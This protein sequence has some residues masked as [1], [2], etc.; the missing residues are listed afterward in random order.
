MVP[1]MTGKL[2]LIRHVDSTK[3]AHEIFDDPKA[4]QDLTSKGEVELIN[5]ISFLR[6]LVEA[7]GASG[8]RL[9]AANSERAEKTAQAIGAELSFKA[10]KVTNLGS[11]GSGPLSGLSEAEAA[12]KFPEYMRTLQL[13]RSGVLSSDKIVRPDGCETLSDY[14]HRISNCVVEI[15]QSD[16]SMAI[17]VG[18]RSPISAICVSLARRYLGYPNDF[19]GYIEIPTGSVTLFDF[20][21]KDFEYIGVRP[22]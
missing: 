3:N 1:P 13:Y 6:G 16:T 14:E 17:V 2:C 7:D 21:K 9:F 12:M 20:G 5:L 8:A 4:N 11:M 19:F 18:H 10:T 22:G 15:L